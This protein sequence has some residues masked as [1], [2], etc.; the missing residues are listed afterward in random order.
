VFYVVSGAAVLFFL[1]VDSGMDGFKFFCRDLEEAGITG[2]K[3]IIFE[4]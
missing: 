4:N 1:Q 2:I 3:H